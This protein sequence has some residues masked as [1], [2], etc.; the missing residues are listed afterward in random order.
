MLGH[1]HAMPLSP[2]SIT[3][4]VVSAGLAL[5][6]LLVCL[7]NHRANMKHGFRLTGGRGGVIEYRDGERLA[8]IGWEMLHRG[9]DLALYI[10]DSG[11]VSPT[12]APFTPKER[13]DILR[14]FDAWARATRTRYE[15]V[16]PE[17]RVA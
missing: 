10:D 13:A 8:Q 5:W 14:R 16:P 1:I 11:W 7:R 9:K 15:I 4:I 2:F 6:L 12:R 3:A 17:P